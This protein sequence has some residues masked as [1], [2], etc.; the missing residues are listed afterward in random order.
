MKGWGSPTPKRSVLWSNSS[1]VQLF[2]TDKKYAK[3]D[4]NVKALADKYKDRAGCKRYKGSSS[5]KASQ[6]GSQDVSPS[7]FSLI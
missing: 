4:R 1:A 6:C 2:R 7:T 3:A 5:M